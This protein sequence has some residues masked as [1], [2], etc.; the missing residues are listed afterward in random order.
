MKRV[1]FV[2]VLNNVM[3]Y[4]PLSPGLL[5]KKDPSLKDYFSQFYD[6]SVNYLRDKDHVDY[7]V[8]PDPFVPFDNENDL[9]I[10]KVPSIYFLTKD[11]G[12]IK[13]YIDTYFNEN[14]SH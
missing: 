9:P 12:K 2:L 14:K 5:Y 11:Y 10:I 13:R 8:M 1:C 7:L 3:S 6:V 4:T